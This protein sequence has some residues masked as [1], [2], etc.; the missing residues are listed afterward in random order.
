MK[1]S[2][3]LSETV[4]HTTTI[5]INPKDWIWVPRANLFVSKPSHFCNL[6]WESQLTAVLQQTPFN[7]TRLGTFTAHYADVCDSVRRRNPTT[8]Y[9]G[10]GEP[11]GRTRK[12]DLYGQRTTDLCINLDAYFK[13]K[14]NTWVLATD[15]RLVNGR[16]QPR[17]QQPLK[18]RFKEGYDILVDLVF[19]QQGLPLR[20]SQRQE[21]VR[22]ENI[23]FQP[24]IKDR[25]ARFS[26]CSDKADLN[27][28]SYPLGSDAI[29]GVLYS[30]APKAPRK[31]S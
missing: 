15:H 25:V 16:L 22:G 19:N 4:K 30:Y 6:D 5:D 17:I 8:L 9:D 11:L 3:T 2:I 27:C 21:Y 23:Y 20:K 10:T 14:N 1:P 7:V 29:H 26:A 28:R 18:Q 24:P 13:E 31:S 12:H